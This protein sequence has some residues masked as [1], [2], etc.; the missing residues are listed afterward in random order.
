MSTFTKET[1]IGGQ[2]ARIQC[3]EIGGQS[4]SLSRGAAT[5]V[6]LEGEWFDDVRDPGHRSAPAIQL[7]CGRARAW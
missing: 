2:P 5:I 6:C 1:L 7:R 3:L 4:H